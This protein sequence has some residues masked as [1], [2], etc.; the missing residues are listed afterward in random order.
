M[1]KFYLYNFSPSSSAE[2]IVSDI[3]MMVE[4]TLQYKRMEDIMLFVSVP[5]ASLEAVCKGVEERGLVKLSSQYFCAEK[6]SG[7]P[8]AEQLKAIGAHAGMTGLADRRYI[9]G[10][11]DGFIRKGVGKLLS[12]G[13]K[14]LL[15]FGET[16][17]MQQEGTA[18]A[19]ITEQVREGL[20]DMT[21]EAAYRAALI[22]RPLW[23]FEGE[24]TDL[25]YAF[26]I[27]A[28]IKE[29]AAAAQ[30][31]L[32]EPLPVIY[33]GTLTAMQLKE[34]YEKQMIDGYYADALEMTPKEFTELIDTVG[35]V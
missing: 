30:P 8:T 19:V 5:T 11:S 26:E 21:V 2:Q 18:K 33:G 4:S 13:M 7:M 1:L 20:A 35:H 29:A 16:R 10:E 9:L 15:C 17:Q 31:D 24:T 23:E 25:D 14:C 32:P 27:I 34:L 22:Y 3:N 6:V 28:A 12:I